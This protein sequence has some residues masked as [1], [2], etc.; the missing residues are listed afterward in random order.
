MFVCFQN[1]LYL[2]K[3]CSD[4]TL[5]IYGPSDKR[6]QLEPV[7]VWATTGQRNS[8][9]KVST[10]PSA[11][12]S[13]IVPTSHLQANSGQTMAQTEAIRKQQEALHKAAELRQIFNTLE[14]IDD[15]GRRASVLDTLFS[16]EDILSLPCHPNPPGIATGEL[17]VN[18]MKHQVSLQPYPPF[19]IS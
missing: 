19:F 4:S 10:R 11:S 1:L 5:K 6:S 9:R 8:S 18:L 12:T 14:K 15:E 16:T 2:L 3:F 17:T 7:L 13:A